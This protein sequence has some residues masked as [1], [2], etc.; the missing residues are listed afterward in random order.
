[1]MGL[2]GEVGASADMTAFGTG[3][4]GGRWRDLLSKA[5]SSRHQPLL[6]EDCSTTKVLIVLSQA[7]LPRELPSGRL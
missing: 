1:M 6:S 5:V 2:S 4:E 3:M 7:D